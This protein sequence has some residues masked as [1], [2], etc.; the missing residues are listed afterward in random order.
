MKR[1]EVWTLRDNGYARKARP[2]VIVQSDLF[3][4]D[5]VIL[6]LMTSYESDHIPSR[7]LIEPNENNGLKQV[8]Y[9]MT[10]KIAT[11]DRSILG[12]YVGELTDTQ[13]SQISVALSQVLGLS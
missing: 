4:F 5:S 2:V 3:S 11:V 9:V 12:E 8:S 6:C 13:M 1:G 7:V 10:D